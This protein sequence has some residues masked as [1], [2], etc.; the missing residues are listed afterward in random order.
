MQKLRTAALA[1]SILFGGGLPNA[2]AG[3]II[4]GG[5]DLNDHGFAIGGVNQDGWLYIQNAL[6]AINTNV[7]LG[8][9]FTVDIV[10]LGHATADPALA[11][12]AA[13]LGLS[14]VGYSGATGLTQFFSDL[15]AGTVRPRILYSPGGEYAAA[16][17]DGSESA[18]L[19]ANAAAI[20]DFVA[21]GGGLMSHGPANAIVYSYLTALLPGIVMSTA[22]AAAP[23]ATL[24]PTGQAAFPQVTNQDINAGPCHGSFSGNL[25]GLVPLALDAQGRPFIIGGVGGSITQ[26]PP[27]VVPEPGSMIL[28]GTGL[29]FAALRLRKRKQ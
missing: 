26:P 24:T 2:W 22:C 13:A 20:N 4:L 23:G 5:D 7:T 28:L 9:T 15:A 17:I 18:V 25:G 12:A 3:P 29:A 6:S 10:E 8:G 21:A 27:G 16:S 19:A 11:S 1:V 14:T